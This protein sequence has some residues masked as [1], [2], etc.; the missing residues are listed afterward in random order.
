MLKYG[1]NNLS[2]VFSGIYFAAPEEVLYR[3]KLKGFDDYWFPSTNLNIANYSNLPPGQY[4]FMVAATANG[5]DWS[6]TLEFPFQIK[7][8]IWRTN[9]FY[10]LYVVA[11]VLLILIVLKLRTRSLRKAQLFLR[12]KVNERTQQLREKNMELAKLSIVASETGNAVMIFDQNLNLEWVNEGFTR[13]TGYSKNEII[14]ERGNKIQQLTSNDTLDMILNDSILERKSIVYETKTKH[15]DGHTFWTSSTLT[16]VFNVHDELKNI[17]VIDTDITLHKKMETQIRESLDEKGSLLKEIHHRVKN[18]LQII[19][20]LFN[21]QSSYVSDKSSHKILKESQDRIRS[22]AL[23]HERFYQSDGTSKIDFDDYIKRLCETIMQSQG[24][25]P[26]KIRLTIETEKISLDIDTAVPCG[27]IIN[28][29]VSNAI[30]HAFPTSGGEIL[31]RFRTTQNNEYELTVKDNGTGLPQDVN[32]A[33]ADSL[34]I[35]LVN[36]LSDQ[37]EGKIITENENGFC[38]KITFKPSLH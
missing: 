38:I 37:I 2:F 29:L 26:D 33:N 18:N 15:K 32:F 19:I 6:P 21:L 30:K 9:F 10:F 4:V 36:V 24:A 1:F 7:A 35:Q 17:V 8:P 34:G 13:M 14:K 16:P 22:M 28:E 31:V 23:I 3:W 11:F 12:Q 20:S 5:R 27:L 25:K